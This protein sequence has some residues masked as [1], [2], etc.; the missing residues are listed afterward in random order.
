VRHHVDTVREQVRKL[1]SHT[2]SLVVAVKRQ[3]DFVEAVQPILALLKELI[4]RRGRRKRDDRI[5]GPKHLKSGESVKLPFCDRHSLG[6][7]SV[8]LIHPEEFIRAEVLHTEGLRKESSLLPTRWVNVGL[9]NAITFS[10]NVGLNSIEFHG[11]VRDGTHTTVDRGKELFRRN[12][13]KCHL[14]F[15]FALVFPFGCGVLVFNP[16]EL[17][18]ST[19]VTST[20]RMTSADTL[21]NV[22]GEGIRGATVNV[23]AGLVGYVSHLSGILIRRKD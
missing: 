9:L 18:P 3:I 15:S 16:I 7:T 10:V 13:R 22:V 19:R 17:I 14:C 11:V 23:R 12:D 6:R 2:L 1:L 20:T 21:V 8:E 5:L 4:A